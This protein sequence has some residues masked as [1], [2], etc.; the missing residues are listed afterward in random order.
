MASPKPSPQQ[1]GTQTPTQQQGQS[2]PPVA[3]QRTQ[4]IFK[5]WASI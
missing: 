1:G 4:P 3:Q 2:V 5:D